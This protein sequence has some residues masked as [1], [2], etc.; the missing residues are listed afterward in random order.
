MIGYAWLAAFALWFGVPHVSN[1]GNLH[2][3][4]QAVGKVGM[5]VAASFAAF[6]IG[7]L[8]DDL[9]APIFRARRA[10]AFTSDRAPGETYGALEP[11]TE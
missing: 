6:M 8:S 1:S 4:T 2:E 3:L 10:R 7:S 9:I 5:A 11:L